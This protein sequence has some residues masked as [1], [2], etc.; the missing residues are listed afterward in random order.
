MNSNWWTC[1][2]QK[3]IRSLLLKIKT[4]NEWQHYY[5]KFNDNFVFPFSGNNVIFGGLSFDKAHELICA[6]FSKQY[7]IIKKGGY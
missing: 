3:F 1:R 4:K 7:Y 2:Q 5:L 6:L